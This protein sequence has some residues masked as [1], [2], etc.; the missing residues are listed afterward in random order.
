MIFQGVCPNHVALPYGPVNSARGISWN[1]PP[2]G[3]S[4]RLYP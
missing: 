3:G 1:T 4:F 2:P